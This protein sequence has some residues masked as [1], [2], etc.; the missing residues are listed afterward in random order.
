MVGTA[1]FF[2]AT[3]ILG[4]KILKHND[5]SYLVIMDMGID[6]LASVSIA[7]LFYNEKLTLEKMIGL[8]CVLIG[9][10]IIN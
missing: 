2:S 4:G 9:V 5:I 1:F 6:L 7:Y 8:V 10:I 3:M